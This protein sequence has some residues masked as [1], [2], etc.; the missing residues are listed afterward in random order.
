MMDMIEIRE[1]ESVLP[2]LTATRMMSILQAAEGGDVADLFSL[3][4]D[5]AGTDSHIGNEI[6]KRKSAVL[7][8]PV[9]LRPW[10]AK[11][12]DD[13]EAARFCERLVESQAFSDLQSWLLNATLWP[14]AVAEKVYRPVA[15][16]FALTGIVA[17][18]YQLLDYQAGRLQILDVDPASHL[19]LRGSGRDPDPERYIIHRGHTLPVPDWWG[20]RFRSILFWWLLRTM[21]RQWWATFIER[22]GQPFFK[23]KYQDDAGRNVLHQAFAMSRKLGGIALSKNTEVEIIQTAMSDSSDAHDRF[24]QL[25]NDEISRAIVG[26]TLSSTASPTGELGGGTAGLQ[27]EVR[28]DLRRMDARRLAVTLRRQLLEQ[29]LRINGRG[30]MPP[31]LSFGSETDSA[32]KAKVSMV[33]QLATAG[34]EPTDNGLAQLSE[35]T[36]IE[37]Q[38]RASP[39]P[40]SMPFSAVPLAASGAVSAQPPDGGDAELAEAFTG[41]YA[42]LREIILNAESAEDCIQKVRAWLNTNKPPR[43]TEIMEQVLSA[44]AAQGVLSVRKPGRAAK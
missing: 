15:G 30:G 41:R 5:V 21:G 27:G 20:G 40:V 17:V 24:I 13:V 22:F 9:N 38:R 31:V 6:E 16:G 14:V 19:P 35:E 10:D 32:I 29:Y 12:A 37:L 4:R 1:P 11:N 39:Q 28:E 33:G 3:Y 23:G 42:P 34:F 25:C 7:G 43:A 26:Q 18:P 36:G 44:Y 2:G 8:D